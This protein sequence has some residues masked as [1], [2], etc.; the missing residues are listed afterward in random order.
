MLRGRPPDPMSK[1]LKM[2]M[3]GP[4]GCGKTTACC[5]FPNAYIVDAERG[6]ENY[7]KLINASKSLVFRTTDVHEAIDEVKALLTENHEYRTLVIDPI[8]PLYD[9]LL[10]KCEKKTGTEFGRH[11]GE[12]NKTMKR[13]ANLIMALDMN[14]IITAHAKKE[15]GQNL[16][17]IGNTFD[18][19]KKLDYWFD[20]VVELKRNRG[21]GKRI[22]SVN[23]TRIEAFPDGDQFEW[24]Y[25]SI[26]E[27]YGDV[28]IRKAEA[29]TL[30]SDE[31]V[32]QLT[33]LLKVV[34]LPEGTEDKWLSK[35][36][37]ETWEDMPTDKI[38]K[39]IDNIRTR[40]AAPAAA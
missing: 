29:I 25:D 3:F 36:G 2:F 33:E 38:Q 7:D 17:V 9:D 20:L 21:D 31:Q 19:W 26:R 16:A 32:T 12:A 24:S 37:V 23:K 39:C 35:A 34:K 11:Y 8:T 40:L 14:V 27:R 22:A 28:I 13:L 10:E 15:Y 4:A 5:Q 18:A 30:A 1:R 6:T